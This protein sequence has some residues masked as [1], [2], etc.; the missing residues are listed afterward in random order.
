MRKVLQKMMAGLCCLTLLFGMAACEKGNTPANTDVTPGITQSAEPTMAPEPTVAPEPTKAPEA[1]K[2]PEVTKAPEVTKE[3]EVTEPLI[4]LPE[5]SLKDAAAEC[6]FSFGTVVSA[7][8]SYD[9]DYKIMVMDDFNSVTAA[10]EMKAYSMLNQSMSQSSPNGM[11]AIDFTQADSIVSMAE[12][13]GIGVRGHVLV[14]DAYMCDWFFRE[15]YKN[16]TPYV[17]KETMKTR[18]QYYI[19]KVITHFE[20]EF[21]GVVYCW[22]VVNEAVGDSEADYDSSDARHVR[23]W[24]GTTANQFYNIIGSDYIE[25]SF[26]YAK[27]VVE[28]LQKKN[29]EVSIALFYNDYNTFYAEKRDAICEVVKS[30][31]S[32]AKDANG[33]Y[34]KL[35]DGVG[36]QS[37]IGGYGYQEGCLDPALIDMIREAI[38]K[39]HALDVEVHVTEMAVRNYD[40]TL[41]AEHAEYYGD[42]ME[43]YVELNKKA[44]MV[45]NISIWGINDAPW[46]DENNGNYKQNSPYC[47]IFDEDYKKKDAYYEVLNAM[48]KGNE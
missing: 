2:V 40:E 15:G 6:G 31:N 24:R 18:L 38:E 12:L 4:E 14:W 28:K 43:M 11:P 20:E 22:D 1:T 21:P 41:M 5:G 45:T 44:P 8:S 3:P 25:L 17:D 47:G 7:Y 19:E 32:Y 30:I 39:Y 48:K 27:D 42:L 29:P 36:M 13:L 16:D 23:T 26:L 9:L 10:N 35:C 33:K 34:R 46:M 37:Y